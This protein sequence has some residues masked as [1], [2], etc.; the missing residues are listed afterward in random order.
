MKAFF[1]ICFLVALIAN[2]SHCYLLQLR[3]SPKLLRT[4]TF[5][6]AKGVN[7][8]QLRRTLAD[9]SQ[10]TLVSASSST[11]PS[12]VPSTVSS[13]DQSEDFLQK[14]KIDG[15][16]EVTSN[17]SEAEIKAQVDSIVAGQRAMVEVLSAV[18]SAVTEKLFQ[19]G[20]G[21]KLEVSGVLAVDGLLDE[22][23]NAAVA[24]AVSLI[25]I[26]K[27]GGVEDGEIDLETRGYWKNLGRADYE[28]AGKAVE[29]IVAA[30]KTIGEICGSR[31]S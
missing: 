19:E 24:K 27:E 7:K 9:A 14:A 18:K 22:K 2:K 25:D 15:V 1:R 20:W 21:V 26:A 17:Q 12:T 6:C 30:S 23:T 5:L 8:R 13:T 31:R 28:K 4:T 10:D 3:R 16:A 11:A 29:F